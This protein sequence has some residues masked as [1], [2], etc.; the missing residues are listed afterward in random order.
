[1]TTAA[2]A[3]GALVALRPPTID[4]GLVAVFDTVGASG[5]QTVIAG[6]ANAV[7][8]IAVAL[9][10]GAVAAG[11]TTAAAVDIGFRPVL[12][13]IIAGGGGAARCNATISASRG[14]LRAYAALAPIVVRRVAA[15]GAVAAW[16]TFTA[17]VDV[18]L[19]LVSGAV[20]TGGND[21]HQGR[22]AVP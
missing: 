9:A 2:V 19:V 14:Q 1:M 21:T 3:I 7:L 20:R 22:R 18:G 10:K 6:A 8:A 13:V 12:H 11:G 16:S 15:A 4:V 17:A 5:W